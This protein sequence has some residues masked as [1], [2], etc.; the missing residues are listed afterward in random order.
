MPEE[1]QVERSEHQD[2]ANIHHQP[3]PE[4][5]SKEREIHSDDHSYHR[6]HIKHD[7]YPVTCAAHFAL[8]SATIAALTA[9]RG[10]LMPPKGSS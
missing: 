5:A 10:P 4:S 7:N 2:D 3:F 1:F 8:R 9:S 6:Q